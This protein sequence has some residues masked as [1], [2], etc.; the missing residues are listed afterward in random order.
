MGLARPQGQLG[1]THARQIADDQDAGRGR[2]FPEIGR[3]HG[4]VDRLAVLALAGPAAQGRRF[5]AGQQVAHR[6]AEQFSAAVAEQRLGLVVGQHD[7]AIPVYCQDGVGVHLKETLE[8]RRRSASGTGLP[9]QEQDRAKRQCQGGDEQALRQETAVRA[10]RPHDPEA[11]GRQQSHNCKADE[12]SNG[13]TSTRF[14]PSPNGPSQQ[15]GQYI[16]EG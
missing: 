2:R 16:G 10:G 15:R 4:Q 11:A 9:G 1:L 7:P 13:E 12:R 5:R 6:A 8:R 3:R 14:I